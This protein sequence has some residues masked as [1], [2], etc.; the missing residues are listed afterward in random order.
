MNDKTR[1]IGICGPSG[2]G[3]SRIAGEMAEKLGGCRVISADS[4]FKPTLPTMVS[5]DDGETYPDWNSPD[6]VD[7]GKLAGAIREAIRKAGREEGAPR[8]VLVEGVMIFFVDEVR[9]LLDLK[10]FVTARPETCL[11]RRI[12]RNMKLF[13]QT[14]EFIGNYYLR[15]ARHREAEFC[16]PTVKYADFVIDNDVSYESDLEKC[17]ESIKK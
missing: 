12:T 7:Y 9:E 11:F 17:V 3:K 8:Y 10:V 2:S 6:S 5:P 15:C 14:P 4:F 16:L 13:G 1:V